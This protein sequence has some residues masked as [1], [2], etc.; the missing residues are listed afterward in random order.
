MKKRIVTAYKTIKAQAIRILNLEEDNKD[1]KKENKNL[2][3]KLRTAEQEIKELSK[4]KF[5]HNPLNSEKKDI[6]TTPKA[7]TLEEILKSPVKKE[8][9]AKENNP[10]YDIEA[11]AY[12]PKVKEESQIRKQGPGRG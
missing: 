8:A 4:E 3:E 2:K 1:L 12:K 5:E 9:E 7:Q 6:A 10:T 11:K